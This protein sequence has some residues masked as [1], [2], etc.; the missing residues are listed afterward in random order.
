[1]RIKHV[2]IHTADLQTSIAFYQQILG[3]HIVR[4]LR[5]I[6]KMPIVFLADDPQLPCIELIEDA[7]QAYSG[8]G[9]S[10][11]FQTDDVEAQHARLTAAGFTPSPIISP[12][13]A[14][15]FFFIKDPNGVSIQ[16]IS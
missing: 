11:G 5:E 1:M 2:T 7:Q 4:D 13:P 3:L 10:I 14:T 6:T 8:S 9:L 15:R 12:N 16:F